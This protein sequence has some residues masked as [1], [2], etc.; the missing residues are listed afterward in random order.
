MEHPTKIDIARYEFIGDI[1]SAAELASDIMRILKQA[2]QFVSKSREKLRTEQVH[3]FAFLKLML[4][5]EMFL[6][7]TLVLYMMGEKSG[8]GYKPDVKVKNIRDENIAYILLSGRMRFDI[9]KHYLQYLSTPSE[10]RHVADTLFNT[11]CYDLVSQ[12]SGN[13]NQNLDLFEHARHIRNHI[14]HRSRI[15]ETKFKSTADYLLG[16][17]HNFTAGGLLMESLKK[18]M[19]FGDYYIGEELSYFGAYC[20]FFG[21]LAAVVAPNEEDEKWNETTLVLPSRDDFSSCS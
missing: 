14:A 10:I 6:E 8:S 12:N 20:V 18:E 5:W 13:K 3:E 21:H 19:Q 2:R 4:S 9:E 16:K 7:R 15:S 1:R 17:N 11:H